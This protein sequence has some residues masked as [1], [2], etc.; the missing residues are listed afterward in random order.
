[1]CHTT[2]SSVP[3]PRLYNEAFTRRV[4]AIARCSYCLQDDHAAPR[5]LKNP[6]RPVFGWF[7]D[8]SD[9]PAQAG[10]PPPLPPPPPHYGQRPLPDIC[11]RYNDG[12]CKQAWCKYRHACHDCQGSHAWLDCPWNRAMAGGWS[13]SP[14]GPPP[15][16]P[17]GSSGQPTLLTSGG[18]GATTAYPKDI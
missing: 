13:R 18:D 17:A 11:R 10:G 9:W 8:P 3:D 5:C 12:W 15:C 2:G 16:N 1:M 6:N 4:R 14:Q 7:P